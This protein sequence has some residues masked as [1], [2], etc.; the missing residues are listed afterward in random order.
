MLRARQ[1]E[2]WSSTSAHLVAEAKRIDQVGIVKHGLDSATPRLRVSA[3]DQL[4][5]LGRRVAAAFEREGMAVVR[6]LIVTS[7]TIAISSSCGNI[8]RVRHIAT[9]RFVRGS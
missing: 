3:A 7:L 4:T 9:L 5:A 2:P 1:K 8:G 6:F